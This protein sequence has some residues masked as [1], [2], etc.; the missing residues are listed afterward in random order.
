MRACFLAGA[1]LI[2]MVGT[3]GVAG[4]QPARSV[5]TVQLISMTGAP[6]PAPEETP[7]GPSGPAPAA[8]LAAVPPEAAALPEAFRVHD[9]SRQWVAYQMANSL[10]PRPAVAGAG[11][12]AGAI[13][14]EDPFAPIGVAQPGVPAYA[15]AVSVAPVSAI[16]VPLW[17]RGGQVFAA[18]AK[19]LEPRVR[20]AKVDTDA[21][22]ALA[23]RFGIR[24]IPTLILLREGREIARQSGALNAGQLRQFVAQALR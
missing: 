5:R 6:S 9:L 14:N 10:A 12:G 22:Q 13:G 1:A 4:A 17:M 7:E 2:S 19:E 11:A 20:L 8:D 15:S 24:S 3:V 18:A 16:S 23:Q 21:Q